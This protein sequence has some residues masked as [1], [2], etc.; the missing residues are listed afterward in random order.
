VIGADLKRIGV[1]G[2]TGRTGAQVVEVLK[3]HPRCRLAAA[4][5][6]A[7]SAQ[8]GV[9]LAGTQVVAQSDYSVLTQCDGV[10]DFST[11]AASAA[12]A[13]VCA[14]R[15]T[16]L[17]VATTG[18]NAEQRAALEPYAQKLPLCCAPNTSIG[19]TVLALAA[20]F[21]HGL[22]GP[23][24]DVEVLEVHHRMKRDA[25]SGTA[26][27]IVQ[28]M[29]DGAAERDGTTPALVFGREGVRQPGEIGV[30]A[31]RGGDVVGD[32]TVYFLGSGER[33]ELTHQANSR[34]VFA[35]GAVT[36]I[37]R[38]MGRPPGLYA[39]RELLLSSHAGAAS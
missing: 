16:P 37:E 39:V 10:I 27:M 36:L 17:L 13:A 30:V 8:R 29:Q 1:V 25:P 20:E 33:I 32:H 21:V 2:A 14:E 4:V 18:H 15:G 35:I 34:A 38:L 7:Q 5:V 28:R 19:A 11:P 31:L 12:V 24:F 3:S 26:R 22:L 9:A 23:T 6:S